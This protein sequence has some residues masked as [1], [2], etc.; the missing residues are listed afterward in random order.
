MSEPSP[1]DLLTAL[2]QQDPQ[3]LGTVITGGTAGNQPAQ[4]RLN[5]GIAIFCQFWMTCEH[6]DAK[7]SFTKHGES[8]PTQQAPTTNTH[9]D[10]ALP[11][12]YL[13]KNAMSNRQEIKNGTSAKEGG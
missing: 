11:S 13:R 5:K 6:Q 3:Q 10:E 9:D 4:I 2:H 8:T 12:R 7:Q 1:G